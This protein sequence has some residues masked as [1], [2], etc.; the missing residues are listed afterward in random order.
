MG[1]YESKIDRVTRIRTVYKL[2][3]EI[4]RGNYAIVRRG[5]KLKPAADEK[6][7]AIKVVKQGRLDREEMKG[8]EEEISLLL[9]VDHPHIV[10]LYEVYIS[11]KNVYL[12]MELLEGGE[13]FDRIV[14]EKFFSEQI[15]AFAVVQI[16]DAL[17]Y[18]HSK[19]I[20]HRDLKPENL[21]YRSNSVSSKVV[22]GDFGLG[23]STKGQMMTTCCGTPQ[24]VAPEVLGNKEYDEKVDCWSV[25]VILYILLCGYPPF[26]AETHPRLYQLIQKGR[27][28]FEKEDW[29]KISDEAKDLIKRLLT[30]DPKRRISAKDAKKHIWV[31]KAATNNQALGNKYQ[32]RIRRFNA[33]RRLRAGVTTTLAICKMAHIMRVFIEE[34][35]ISQEEN[36]EMHSELVATV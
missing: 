30:K 7:V 13:M 33:V 35:N 2:K 36:K 26:Y 23:K 31:T 5:S 21:L 18:C 6:D 3:D 9:Q 1:Q 24:Y 32:N 11:K 4:G 12:V 22:I 29:G 34:N 14:R 16:L 17:I 25:G 8:L 27:F 19:G 10:K 20:C 28:T 15:A